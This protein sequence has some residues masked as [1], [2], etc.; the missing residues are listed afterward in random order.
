MIHH[1]RALRNESPLFHSELMVR[2]SVHPA[3][4]RKRSGHR[5]NEV[6]K[7]HRSER[8]LY[9]QFWFGRPYLSQKS[10]LDDE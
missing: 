8:W 4:N 6:Q 2:L 10:L 9:Y 5:D 7:P 3:P 1:S